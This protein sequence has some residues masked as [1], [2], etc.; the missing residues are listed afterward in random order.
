M[1]TVLT[2]ATLILPSGLTPGE[3]RWED[4]RLTEVGRVGHRGAAV[5]DAGGCYVGPGLID[6]HVH[7]GGGADFMDGTAEAFSTVCRCHLRHGTTRLTPTSTVARRSDY[8]R[9][10]E[11]CAELYAR[12]TGGARIVGAHLYGP[13]FARPARGCHPDRDF[14]P[15]GDPE[16]RLLLDYH[17]L[18][19]LT[20]TIAPELSNIDE[21]VRRYITQGVRFNVGHSHATF[22]QVADAVAWGVSHVDHLFCAMS[23]RARLRQMQPYPMRGGVLEAA[24][25]FDQLTTEVIADGKHLAAELLQLAYKIKGPERLAVVTDAM[26]AVDQPDG[27]YVFG[28]HDSGEPVRKADGVGLTRDGTA[29]ASGVMGLD[30]AI[31]TLH[32]H[33][34]I[35]LHDA[36][37]MASLTPARI[38]GLDRFYGSLEPGKAADVVVWDRSLQVQQVYLDGRRLWPPHCPADATPDTS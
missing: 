36:V 5:V 27:D 1:A 31:R 4:G 2:N 17:R 10:L 34:G 29:L 32:F 3:L 6:L 24:L 20:V 22:A 28:P 9:F 12:D 23:D 14:L 18:F 25:Y 30:H 21:L 33:A 7:G 35:P 8:R 16:A 26:R 37:R 13:F 15:A 11:L 38:L 19:P